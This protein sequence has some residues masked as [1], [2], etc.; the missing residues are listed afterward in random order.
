MDTNGEPDHPLGRVLDQLQEAIHGERVSVQEIVEHL[1]R[2]SFPAIMLIPALL[3]VS[4]LSGIPGVTVA[5]GLIVAITSAQMLFGRKNLWL[6]EFLNR[7]TVPRDRLCT[8]VGWLQRPVDFV[9]RL[10]RPRLTILV[11]RPLVWLPLAI[12]FL[13]G[14]TMPLL[15]L[16]PTSGSIAALAISL[17]ATGLLAR[18]GVV[19][20]LGLIY[21]LGA[22]FLV[23]QLAS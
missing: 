11:K 21:V 9:E 18:D 17:L 4:P 23:W 13:I 20:L 5:V 6:P 8:A 12:M 22:P 14:I 2:H 16:I 10:L 7:R 19:V 15:E 1:G 3:A